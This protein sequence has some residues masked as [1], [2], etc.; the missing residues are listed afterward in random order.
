M[1]QYW[2]V[3]GLQ[4]LF[5]CCIV[6]LLLV[7]RI[8]VQKSRP[9]KKQETTLEA[10]PIANTVRFHYHLGF[11]L[12]FAFLILALM[13][14]PFVQVLGRN[15]ID[16]SLKSRAVFSLLIACFFLVLGISYGVKKGDFKWKRPE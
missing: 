14:L 13:L 9:P 1:I 7:F 2:S 5:G 16:P 6:A 8:A 4:L 3:Y 15:G 10:K 12:S 11:A